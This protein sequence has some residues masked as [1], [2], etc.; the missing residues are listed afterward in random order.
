[1]AIAE[2]L[3]SSRIFQLLVAILIFAGTLVFASPLIG[4]AVFLNT[5]VAPFTITT[6]VLGVVS[7]IVSISGLYAVTKSKYLVTV[8]W[9]LEILIF[10]YT[11]AATSYLVTVWKRLDGSHRYFTGMMVSIVAG[12]VN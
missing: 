7:I 1:M 6:L 12:I 10:V 5:R 8:Q 4:L 9:I 11:I 2:T 3:E